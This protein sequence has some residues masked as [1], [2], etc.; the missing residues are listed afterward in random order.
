MSWNITREDAKNATD[1]FLTEVLNNT[2]PDSG[3][4]LNAR[5]EQAIR[6]KKKLLRLK[7][8]YTAIGALVTGVIYLLF[9]LYL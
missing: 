7:L 3:A 1:E 4:Y 2:R 6:Q 8:K 9:H 5:D